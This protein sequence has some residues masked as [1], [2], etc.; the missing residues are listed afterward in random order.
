MKLC[1][2]VRSTTAILLRS[3]AACFLAWTNKGKEGIDAVAEVLDEPRALNTA[4]ATRG[5]P[6]KRTAVAIRSAVDCLPPRLLPAGSMLLVV[7]TKDILCNR[8]PAS[9]DKVN[10]SL[11]KGLSRYWN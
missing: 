4:V 5:A 1:P 7:A 2:F 9:V 11:A 10:R 6:I 3:L 8:E